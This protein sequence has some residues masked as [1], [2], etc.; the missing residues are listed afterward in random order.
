MDI[1]L[2]L[3]HR[4]RFLYFDLEDFTSYS[5]SSQPASDKNEYYYLVQCC[6]NL[7]CTRNGKPLR[8]VFSGATSNSILP[9]DLVSIVMTSITDVNRNKIEGCFK[10]TDAVTPCNV[11]TED[12]AFEDFIFEYTCV[13]TCKEC[14]P[15]V[16]ITTPSIID[17]N[18]VHAEPFYNGIDP[19]KVEAAMCRFAE[20]TYKQMMQKRH[21]IKYCC[22]EDAMERKIDFEIIKMDLTDNSDICCPTV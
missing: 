12:V 1:D 11:E 15:D 3:G 19:D 22:M 6:D 13:N 16:P 18:T 7:P 5:F 21:G 9:D 8:L 14:L 17:A 10:L 2:Y 4:S 20:V